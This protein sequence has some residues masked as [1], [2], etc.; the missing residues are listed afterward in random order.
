MHPGSFR[1]HAHLT[2]VLPRAATSMRRFIVLL[3]ATLALACVSGT[4]RAQGETAAALASPAPDFDANAITN[5]IRLHLSLIREVYERHLR[6]NPRLAGR[7]NLQFR[8]SYGLVID[9]V[10]VTENTTGDEAFGK[11]IGAA[12]LTFTWPS[13]TLLGGSVRFSYPFVFAPRP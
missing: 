3:S 10:V 11:A 9:D 4:A 5:T 12:L 2:P 7:I 6:S 8:V 1:G 13:T